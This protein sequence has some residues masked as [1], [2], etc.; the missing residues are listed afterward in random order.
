VDHPAHPPAAQ[1]RRDRF[2][3]SPAVSCPTRTACTTVGG[4]ENDAAGSVTV[5]ETGSSES[6]FQ[7]SR[8]PSVPRKSQK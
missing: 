4:N 1:H 7:R 3:F 5:A 8:P 6:G 2:I